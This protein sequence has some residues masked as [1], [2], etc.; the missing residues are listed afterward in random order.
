MA[1]GSLAMMIHLAYYSLTII[2]GVEDG[3]ILT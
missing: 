2:Y 3:D 1:I